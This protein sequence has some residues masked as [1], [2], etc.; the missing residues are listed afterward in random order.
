M[1]AAANYAK[2]N[3]LT[4]L[5]MTK[6]GQNLSKLTQGMPWERVGPMW[7]RFLRLKQKEQQ[8][9]FTYSKMQPQ[10]YEK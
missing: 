3:G 4:T 10:G 2:A 6:A 1:N 9:L 7:Q 5:E 8:D